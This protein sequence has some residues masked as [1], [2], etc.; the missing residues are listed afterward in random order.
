MSARST[1]VGAESVY[2]AAEVWKERALLADDSLF[3]PG[4][5][6]WTPELL[7]EVSRALNAQRPRQ[8]NFWDNLADALVGHQA[9]AFQLLAE[10]IHIHFLPR[11]V[12]YTQRKSAP[13]TEV[14]DRSPEMLGEPPEQRLFT[15]GISSLVMTDRDARIQPFYCVRTLSEVL[16]RWKG[17]ESGSRDTLI[18]NPWEFKEFLFAS[19]Y[20]T[21]NRGIS[22]ADAA[23]ARQLDMLLH[24]IFPDTFEPLFPEDKEAICKAKA[25]APFFT[26]PE[27]D[28]DRKIQQLRQ[29]IEGEL[30]G[31]FDFYDDDILKYWKPWEGEKPVEVFC[32]GDEG[33]QPR[34]ESLQSLADK[35]YLPDDTFLKE[36]VSLLEEKRQVI[37]QGPP[38][39]GKTFVAQALARHLAGSDD[40][41]TLVQFHPSY[42]YEDFVQGFRPKQLAGGQVGFELRKG[43]LLEIAEKARDSDKPHYLII[44][45]INRGALATVFGELYFL[46]EY[47]E[48]KMR[49]QYSTEGE[50]FALPKNLFIIGTMNTAD[51]SIAMVDLALRRRFYFVEFHPDKEPV[52]GVLQQWLEKNADNV[53]DVG[54]VPGVVKEANQR[55]AD[56][57]AAIGPSYFMQEGL[58]EEKVALIWKHSVLPYIAERLFDDRERLADFDLEKLK[59]N[60]PD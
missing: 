22:G 53:G 59:G 15:Q 60:A 18:E 17:L 41:V 35:L 3:T 24:L 32:V 31:D 2:A 55:L 38:G 6:I 48:E 45:E 11:Y 56:S 36:I 58:T 49:L 44:D 4:T 29:S 52:S 1:E 20:I 7:E 5:P 57:D 37:F 27:L 39:T 50:K 34:G 46:L 13:I 42:A 12:D 47:R 8:A 14:I 43:P 28:F 26:S 30:G 16:V 9:P 25:F 51:R 10:A 33:T 23:V 54:W 40:R 19:P 21:Q